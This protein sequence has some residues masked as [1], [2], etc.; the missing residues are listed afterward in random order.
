MLAKARA[1]CSRREGLLGEGVRFLLTG[2]LAAATNV[3]VTNL[4]AYVVGLPFELAFVIG[5]GTAI[6]GQFVLFRVW[7]W[8]HHEQ[9]ARPV[10]HQVTLFLLVALLIYGFT[11]ICTWLLPGALGVP[12]EVVYLACVAASPLI[13]FLVARNRIFQGD[14]A[15]DHPAGVPAADQLAAVP[16]PEDG[17]A[18]PLAE[19]R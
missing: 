15:E 5:F 19:G 11:A 4:L 3:L 7:V 6:A 8:G 12:T 13:N 16:V 9:F 2:G 10:H 18:L 14:V 1:L 17:P